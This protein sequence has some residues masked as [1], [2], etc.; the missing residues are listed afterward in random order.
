VNPLLDRLLPYPFERLGALLA[1]VE[2]PPDR[3]PIA[4]SVGEP[5]E[6]PPAFIG[7]ALQDAL[8]GLGRYPKTQG[9]PALREAIAE[10]L[11]GRYSLAAGQVDPATQVQP[12]NGTR[13]ALFS[14]VQAAV[15]PTAGALVAMPN[16]GYQIYEGAALLA[17]AEPRYLD[18]GAGPGFRPDLDAVAPA[19]WDRCALLF[20]CSPANP[21]GAALGLEDM[22]AVIELADRHDFV[23]A[24]DECYAEIYADEDAPPVGLLEACHRL[25]RD[26]FNRCVVFHSLS[27]RSSVPGLRSG[28]VAGDAAALARYRLYRTYHGCAMPPATQAAS[29]AAWRDEDHVRQTRERY[30]ARFDAVLPV[31]GE[32]LD[33]ARPDG[34]FYLWAGTPIDDERFCRE[35]YRRQH[36][37][38]LPGSYL[39][40]PTAAGDPGRNRVRLSLVASLDDCVEAAERIRH[41]CRELT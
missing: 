15:D 30:R 26:D 22:A 40:R 29:I 31:L 35:L 10:W 32:V 27:K 13:E 18:A 34:A 9:L 37:T 3:A 1:G 25:G 20:L 39:S 33:V 38:L 28:F 12:V 2:P 4:L 17:G 23:I 16:P 8:S 21:T 14:F 24:A 36:V 7:A 19:E 6:D 5:G 11:E 41:C